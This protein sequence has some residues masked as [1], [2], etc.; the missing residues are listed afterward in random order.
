MPLTTAEKEAQIAELRESFDNA[1]ATVFVDY[2]GVDVETITELRVKFREAGIVYKVAKNNLVRKALAGTD[3]E[4]NEALDAALK[5]MTGIAWSNEDPSTAAKVLRDFR[6]DKKEILAKKDEPE[7][8]IAK[9]ALL[10]GNVMP[11]EQVETT[12]ASM[13]GK[14][15]IRAQLLA[16]L[17]A[18]AQNLVAQLAAPAQ[19]L[20]FVFDAIKRKQEE[21]G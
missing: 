18:P 3:L 5:G 10:D 17:L 19:N 4:G 13:P 16:T 1:V 6:K 2:R 11:G 21:E 9:A 14:D 15:E 7:K 8:L 20:A 12:L